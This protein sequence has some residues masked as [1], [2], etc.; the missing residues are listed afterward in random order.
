M[1]GMGAV[2]YTH[3]DIRRIVEANPAAAVLV[4]EA[5]ADFGAQSA[6]E[7]IDQYP[8]LL[9]V[10]TMSKSRSL[11]GMRIG[12]ALGSQDLI[13]GVNLSLIHIS[14]AH[15]EEYLGQQHPGDSHGYIGGEGGAGVPAHPVTPQD[16][17]G[18]DQEQQEAA[19]HAKLLPADGEDEVG[20]S[21]RES[22]TV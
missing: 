17:E 8:N 10:R 14:H 18:Q 11:A 21:G 1:L 3:L 15:I 6:V 19:H 9:V 22:G 13:A 4:D 20:L 2:S 5:Y 16:D 12:Y 7:L